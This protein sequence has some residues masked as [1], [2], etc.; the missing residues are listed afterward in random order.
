M[1]RRGMGREQHHAIGLA[2][3]PVEQTD[4]SSDLGTVVLVAGEEIGPDIESREPG[5]D[6][7]E[8]LAESREA[9]IGS[10]SRRG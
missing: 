2:A 5:F 1:P 8:L 9:G 4:K 10:L 3:E 7:E 6:V